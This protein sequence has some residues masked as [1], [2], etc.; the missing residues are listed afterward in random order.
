[1]MGKGN[2]VP[3]EPRAPLVWPPD[4]SGELSRRTARPIDGS[5]SVGGS[6]LSTAAK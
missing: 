4:Q 3:L 6:E 1:M 5:H 2:R